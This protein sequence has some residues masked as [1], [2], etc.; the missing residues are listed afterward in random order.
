[1]IKLLL[2]EDDFS[3][4][5]GLV[6]A[7]KKEKYDVRVANTKAEALSL[8]RQKNFNIAIL[9]IMLPDGSG[10]EICNEI[11]KTSSMPIIFLTA[12]DEETDITM[13]LDIG[14]DDYITK[15]AWSFTCKISN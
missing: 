13:G 2:T 9:D 7:L 10:Y 4:I 15:R 3:L 12:L 5:N 1:M 6:Y 14:G 8:I 11:R